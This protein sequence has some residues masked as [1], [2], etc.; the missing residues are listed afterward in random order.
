MTKIT[1]YSQRIIGILSII[2]GLGIWQI[3]ELKLPT[4]VA[5]PIQVV[6]ALI[7][8][9][10]NGTLIPDVFISLERVLEGFILALICAVILGFILG[11]YQPIRWILNPWLQFLRMIPP[12]A[13]IP[14]VVVYLGVGQPAKVF[15]IF[16]AAFLV[17]LVT[18]YQGVRQVD[19]TLVRA[20]RVLGCNDWILF[21]RV[22]LPASIPHIFTAMRLGIAAAWTTL[23]AAELI[24]ASHGLGFMIEQAS[25]YFEMPVV[26]LG[27]TIIG[28]LG[29][30]MDRGILALEGKF[31][32]WQEKIL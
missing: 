14:L 26:Y 16:F 9:L 23:V 10:Q 11:W 19:V 18:I 21:F 15:V 27:I 29:I 13:L 17:M 4:L 25:N 30:A 12:I 5:G 1:K 32:L 6:Y 8:G 31:T 2:V 7:A 24:A 3:A 28:A 22:I 20:A